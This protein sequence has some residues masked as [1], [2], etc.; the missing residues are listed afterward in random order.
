ML[1]AG[2]ITEKT[3]FECGSWVHE[4]CNTSTCDCRCHQGMPI[5]EIHQLRDMQHRDARATWEFYHGK[6]RWDSNT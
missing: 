2:M 3:S 1:I 4:K 5:E 6:L